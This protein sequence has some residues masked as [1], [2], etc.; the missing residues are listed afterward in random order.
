MPAG[1][2][3]VMS[4][5]L[6]AVIAFLLTLVI[7]PGVIRAMKNWRVIDT[8][9]HRSSHTV[10]TP[11]G[12]GLGLAVVALT[13]IPVFG[14]IDQ[15]FGLT[16]LAVALFTLLGFVDDLKSLPSLGRLAVQL[17][18]AV[19]AAYGIA[20]TFHPL[21][22]ATPLFI[23]AVVNAFNFMDGIN[24]ISGATMA[25]GGAYFLYIGSRESDTPLAVVGATL[26]GTGLGFLPFNVPNARVFLGDVGSYFAGSLIG[27]AS[28][29]VY[30]RTNLGLAAAVAPCVIYAADTAYTMF[31]RFRRGE[32]LLEPHR[33]HIY[34]R[35]TTGRRSHSFTS[36]VVAAF[37]VAACL[38]GSAA[39]SLG[40]PD[41]VAIA[42]LGGVAIGYLR[43]P[44][45]LGEAQPDPA[46]DSESV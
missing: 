26:V 6:V 5:L 2:W 32:P 43:L 25:V 17:V 22:L 37:T 33:E 11:R 23:V 45:L 36:S 14:D 44:S 16:V 38:I 29:M 42:L 28:V 19:V 7:T 21:V 31:R 13:L 46:L 27:V 12:G 35:I 9:N 30:E 4:P 15:R 10:V 3:C 39:S 40:W 41:P 8:P 24:G 20:P 34:Q 1:R 18:L